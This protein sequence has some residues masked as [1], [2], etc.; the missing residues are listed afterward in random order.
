MTDEPYLVL[1]FAT[2]AEYKAWLDERSRGWMLERIARARR[3]Q[4]KAERERDELR[5]EVEELRRTLH[6]GGTPLR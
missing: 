1:T 3:Q 5:E 2:P 4:L 6:T